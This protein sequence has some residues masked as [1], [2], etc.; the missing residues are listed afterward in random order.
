VRLLEGVVKELPSY[1][2]AHVLLARLY[3]KLKR[4]DEA[5]REQVIIEKLRIEEQ[6]RQPTAESQKPGDPRK[7][8]LSDPLLKPPI[9]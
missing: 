5:K 9:Q 3:F 6:Q 4:T 1:S 7:R 8:A 2:P